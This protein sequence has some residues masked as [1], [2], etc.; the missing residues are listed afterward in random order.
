MKKIIIF[1]LL[2][3]WSGTGIA[4]V[5]AES[6]WDVTASGTGPYTLTFTGEGVVDVTSETALTF[7]DGLTGSGIDIAA[8]PTV[9]F[10]A[11]TAPRIVVTEPTTQQSTILEF[12]KVDAEEPATDDL[13]TP[14]EP[15]TEPEVK[16]DVKP[17]TK[18]V[19]PNQS[20]PTTPTKEKPITEAKPAP[21]TNAKATKGQISGT[22]WYDAN[23][24]GIRQETEAL[25]DDV[26][27]FLITP[28][29]D[30]TDMAIT[31]QGNYIFEQVTP[32]TYQ[33]K[34]DGYD[35]GLYTFTKPHQDSDVN[36]FG[37]TN[38]TIQAGD[39]RVIDAGMTEGDEMTEP[40]HFLTLTNFVD[41]NGDQ[42]PQDKEETVPMTYTL[43]DTVTGETAWTFEDE[44]D[45]QILSGDSLPVGTYILKVKA[46]AGYTVKAMHHLDYIAFEEDMS[47][48]KDA[49]AHLLKHLKRQSVDA[50]LDLT[51]DGGGTM[52]A[53]E[54]A[55]PVKPVETPTKVVSPVK[56][57][58]PVATKADTAPSTPTVTAERLPQAG[59]DKPFPFAIVGSMSAV[60]GL[61]LLI[62]KR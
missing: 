51:R 4:P 54:L 38:V 15:V 1:L 39:V 11:E 36:T 3:M 17:D 23:N 62:R 60:A 25:L 53:V 9:T 33:V 7:S 57:T 21:A 20:K 8:H 18:P 40:S 48:A 13:V 24:D 42:Q 32:G 16:P 5:Q 10:T 55:P 50:V 47:E 22:V 41:A 56:S 59:E 34:I 28:R 61:W 37:T 52:V 31:E 44:G 29:G 45:D 6:K 19:T 49:Q 58:A 12:P 46:P 26:S 2:L 43:L 30:V 35:I 14:E 27:V